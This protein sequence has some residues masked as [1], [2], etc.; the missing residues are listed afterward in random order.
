MAWNPMSPK[1]R[2]RGRRLARATALWLPRL[3]PFAGHKLPRRLAARRVHLVAQKLPQGV[4]DPGFEALVEEIFASELHP[5]NRVTLYTRG[6]EAF[7]GIYAALDQARTEIL[8]ES[9]ILKDD[10]VGRRILQS[11]TAAVERGVQVRVLADAVGSGQTRQA[12]WDEM[13]RRGIDARLFHKFLPFLRHYLRRD[14]RKIIVVDRKVAFTGGMNIAEEYG[15]SRPKGGGTAWRDTHLRVEGSVAVELAVVFREGWERALGDPF[16]I[17][18][19]AL[20]E[21]EGCKI[22]VLDSRPERGHAET[23][24]VLAAAT[25]ATQRYLWLTNAYFAPGHIASRALRRAARRGVDVRLLLPGLTD[26]PIVRHAGHGYYKE[27]LRDGVRIYEYQAAPLH[28]KTLVTDDHLAVVGSSNLDYRS[29][30][31]NAECNLL[32]LGGDTAPRLAEAFRADLELAQEITLE[33]WE[34]RSWPHKLGDRCAKG[35]SALL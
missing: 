21:D 23:A 9:Y 6:E 7:A 19:V 20:R 29:F 4:R 25:A 33:E 31:L 11:L 24:S 13:N 35:I 18:A 32:L 16:P 12:F 8:L 26:V 34:E 27:L 14:H 15:S 28:A 2:R 17:E 1:M 22:L 30:G 5:G 3:T 10:D